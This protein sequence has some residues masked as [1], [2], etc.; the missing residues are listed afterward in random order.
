MRQEEVERLDYERRR[1]EALDAIEPLANQ[2][3]EFERN[4]ICQVIELLSS[5]R[6][7]GRPAS[8]LCIRER[9]RR[10]NLR[11]DAWSP[12]TASAADCRSWRTDLRAM[13]D[14]FR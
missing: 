12:R 13:G 7:S 9:R 11:S 1:I 6:L 4:V 8:S 2:V 5:V 3:R 14:A 10:Q